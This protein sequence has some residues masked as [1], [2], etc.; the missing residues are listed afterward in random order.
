MRHDRRGRAAEL[1]R[2]AAAGKPD[3]DT[4]AAVMKEIVL[5][6]LAPRSAPEYLVPV[7]PQQSP[8]GEERRRAGRSDVHRT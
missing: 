3:R 4:V 5:V 6:T 8:C 1:E 2:T 7:I